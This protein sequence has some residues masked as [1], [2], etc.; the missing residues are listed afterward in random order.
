M[1]AEWEMPVLK[2]LMKDERGVETNKNFYLC[3]IPTFINTSLPWGPGMAARPPE[4]L[5]VKC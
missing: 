1:V 2:T 5:C 4:L 3:L